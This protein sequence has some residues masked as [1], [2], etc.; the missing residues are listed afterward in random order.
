ME[1]ND[2]RGRARMGFHQE[3]VEAMLLLVAIHEKQF[4]ELTARDDVFF[5]K[6]PTFAS[7]GSAG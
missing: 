7:L 1:G 4:P 5:A 3:A 6:L 2:D